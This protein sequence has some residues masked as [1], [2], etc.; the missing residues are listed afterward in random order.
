M[1]ADFVQ[2]GPELS[3]PY[4]RN[5]VLQAIL[6]HHFDTDMFESI[7]ATLHSLGQDIVE[8]VDPIGRRAE[9]SEPKLVPYS[10]WGKPVYDI[11]VSQHWIWLHHWSAKNGLIA[12]GYE[13][14]YGEQTRVFQMAK[15]HLFHPS[16]AFY[17][18]PLAMTDGAAK[19]MELHKGDNPAFEEAFRNLN[20]RDGSYFWTS[21]QWMTE[22][23]GGSDVSETSTVATE[24]ADGT[25]SLNGIKWFSS[26]TTS[27]MA[28]GLA[29]IEGSEEL[30]LFFIPVRNEDDGSLNGIEVMRLKDKMGTKALPTAE[31]RLKNTV[32]HL[33][34][35]KGKGVRTVATMLNITRLYNSI[36]SVAQLNRGLQLLT[37]YS[38]KRNAFGKPL[39]DHH[40]HVKMLSL[41]KGYYF[42][43]A[44]LSFEVA[45]LLGKDDLGTA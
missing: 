25:Y 10:A 36:C 11:E 39:T 26:A 3:N 20:S 13:R 1:S 21:G 18:C 19:V 30:S 9:L 37:D 14:A 27:Q 41:Q 28:L 8:D 40:L 4:A 45:S 7:D 42:A 34:G 44:V 32:A 12:D 17:S 43:G 6:T 5:I 15:L 2:E 29:K 31:L 23:T 38:S 35:E 33:V 22:K 16:S 24:N